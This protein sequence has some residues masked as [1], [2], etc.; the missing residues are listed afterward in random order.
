M[1]DRYEAAE[2]LAQ[3]HYQS[4][5]TSEVYVTRASLE[6][7]D[8]ADQPIELL[9]VDEDTIPTGVV[10]LHFGPLPESGIAY[11]STIIE[12]TPE[13]YRQIEKGELPL[14]EGWEERRLIPRLRERVS[15]DE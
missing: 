15:T 11:S 2:R 5:S 7:E 1:S 9:E 14:P 12:V 8:H 3:I 6:A 13:E 4:E 10:P